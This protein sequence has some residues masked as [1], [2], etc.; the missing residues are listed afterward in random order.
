MYITCQIFGISIATIC[1]IAFTPD[2]PRCWK[3]WSPTNTPARP[4]GWR[5]TTGRV[6][7]ARA[8]A[9]AAREVHGDESAAFLRDDQAAP[10]GLLRAHQD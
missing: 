3:V 2:K 9:Q 4:G 6:H 7:A 8:V 10:A 5:G 1:T